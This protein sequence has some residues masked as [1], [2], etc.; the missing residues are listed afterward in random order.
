MGV[1]HALAAR[2]DARARYGTCYLQMS[3]LA[4]MRPRAV[5]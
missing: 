1:K 2:A 3:G 4:S 5:V